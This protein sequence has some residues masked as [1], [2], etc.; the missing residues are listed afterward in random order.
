MGERSDVNFI[1]NFTMARSLGEVCWHN[2]REYPLSIYGELTQIYPRSG[3]AL[4]WS[5]KILCGDK[6]G[7]SGCLGEACRFNEWAV[8]ITIHYVSSIMQKRFESPVLWP[9]GCS[10][11]ASP[12]KWTGQH[13]QYTTRQT[14]LMALSPTELC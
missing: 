11:C 8:A 4:N 2:S 14:R 3:M 10:L 7:K 1:Q 5:G 13:V 9:Q 12:H 6:N